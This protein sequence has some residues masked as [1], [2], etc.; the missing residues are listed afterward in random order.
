MIA[1]RLSVVLSAL[2]ASTAALALEESAEDRS[3]TQSQA[4]A[5]GE[6]FTFVRVE[7]DSTGGYGEAFYYYDGRY[8]LRWETDYP[9]GDENF[10]HR[11]S[12][13]TT[14]VPH[15]R[16]VTRRLTDADVF[17]FPFLYMCDVGWMKLSA[18]ERALLAAYLHKGGFLWVDDFWGQ[19]EWHNLEAIFEDVLPGVA[20]QDI[21]LD[22]PLLDTVS[23]LDEI[24]QVPSRDFAPL[25]HDPAWVHRYP[26]EPMTPSHLRG[27]FDDKG[28]LMV[29][30]TH[31]T[32]IGDGWEREA[33]GEWYFEKYSTV[34]YAMGVNI[35]VYALSH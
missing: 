6:L 23:P 26:A 33:Y 19:A 18:E 3:S 2:L 4:P 5:Q 9:Q 16:S 11:F 25:G 7:Y 24:P 13:L 20:W 22:H 35:V 21:P 27:L 14:T 10:L 31:N 8:W 17:S 34:A 29:V 32:D 1:R 15:L 28:R 30:A 12:E